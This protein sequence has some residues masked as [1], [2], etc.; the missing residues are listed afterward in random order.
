VGFDIYSQNSTTKYTSG[1]VFHWDGMVIQ[2]LSM[3]VGFG[4]IGS[5]LTQITN[6]KGPVADVLHGFEGR[7]WGLG[8]MAF[9]VARLEKP[10]VIVQLRWVNEFEVTN[11]LKG[12]MLMLGLTLKLN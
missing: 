3:R 9:Y 12:N 4:V 11:L 6:D 1:T 10:G 8:P 7:A 2:Y 5:N